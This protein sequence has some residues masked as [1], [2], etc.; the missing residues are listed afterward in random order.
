MVIFGWLLNYQLSI[1]G[2]SPW[3]WLSGYLTY[4]LSIYG[5]FPWWWLSGDLTTTSVSMVTLHGDSWVVSWLPAQ[6]PWWWLHGYLTTSSVSMVSLHGDGWVITWLP[7]QYPWW[8]SIVMVGWLLFDCQLGIHGD[9]QWWWLG[10]Y[11]T[12]SSESML[13]LHGDGWVVTWLPAQHSWW[14]SI[15]MV[16]WLLDYQHPW[17]VSMVM[18]TWLLGQH[19]WWVSMVMVDCSL[20]FQLSIHGKSMVMVEWLLGWL[21]AQ[22][23]LYGEHLWKNHFKVNNFNEIH[24]DFTQ[25]IQYTTLL[26]YIY[27]L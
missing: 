16:G 25:P 15:V 1:H 3:W 23:R 17:W 22:V 27:I 2:E 4:Q 8:V 18:V 26:K 9:Y 11:L 12:T 24:K 19:P 6:Y 10:G 5:Q 21:P 20:D 13:S 7:A 14:V